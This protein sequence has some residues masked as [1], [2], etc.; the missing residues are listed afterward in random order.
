M[1]LRHDGCIAVPPEYRKELGWKPGD[2]VELRVE[3][4]ALVVR[5]LPGESND[6]EDII[7][8]MA[9]KGELKLTTKEIMELLRGSE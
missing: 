3:A 9:G 1:R 5:N 8:K 2:E 6:N 7:A 4:G